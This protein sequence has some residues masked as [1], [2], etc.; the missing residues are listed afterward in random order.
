MGNIIKFYEAI[1]CRRNGELMGITVQ[2]MLEIEKITSELLTDVDFEEKPYVDIVALVEKAGFVV[3]TRDMDIDTTG[4]LFVNDETNSEKKNRLI[5]VNTRFRNSENESDVVFKKSR[6]ITA[7]E[8]GHFVLHKKE[9][10][11]IY[12]HRDT[13]H[14]TEEPELEADYFARSILMPKEQFLA[15]YQALQQLGSGDKEFI[16]RMLS[17]LFRVTKNKVRKRTE[18]LLALGLI[19]E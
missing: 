12:A 15:Y 19:T 5:L 14:R 4:C 18:D 3:E 8:Y 6:F 2:R 16:N 9:G 7:H 17:R 1:V 11:S 13:D 10:E